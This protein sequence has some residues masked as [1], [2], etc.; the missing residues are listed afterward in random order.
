M[1]KPSVS[2]II[3]A[4]NAE[5]HIIQTIES[6]LFQDYEGYIE[7]I[8]IDDCS[9]DDTFGVTSRY[10]KENKA[11]R[12]RSLS[13]LK[14]EENMRV[15]RTRNKGVGLAKGDYICFLDSD[16]FWELSKVSRQMEDLLAR[17][18]KKNGEGDKIPVLSTTGRAFVNEAGLPTGKIVRV[19]TL[20]SFTDNLKTNHISCS[21]A[22]VRRDVAV[23]FPMKRDDLVEDYICWLEIMK[24]YGPAAGLDES[25]LNYRITKGSRSS[26]K[27]KAARTQYKVYRYFGISIPMS[28]CYMLS[29]MV[30]GIKK[31]F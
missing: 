9:A 13:V 12:K 28:I 20:I 29:Y 4:Y 27:L 24:K 18:E 8:V 5:K 6:A 23:E 15:A 30:N 21:G 16:D 10:A 11:P 2:V 31:H 22:M 3:P 17:D 25:L 19:P 1:A 14:N 7:V 26:N